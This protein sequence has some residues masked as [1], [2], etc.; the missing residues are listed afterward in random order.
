MAYEN[1]PAKTLIYSFG[2]TLILFQR[3]NGFEL[4][5]KT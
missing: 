4:R 2:D 3:I 1:N 5:V